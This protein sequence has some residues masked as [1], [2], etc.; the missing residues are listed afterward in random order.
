MALLYLA[1]K[2]M[3]GGFFIYKAVRHFMNP[4]TITDAEGIHGVSFPAIRWGMTGL[5]FLLCGL[6]FLFGYHPFYGLVWCGSALSQGNPAEEKSLNA[7]LTPALDEG[8]PSHGMQ[9]TS[10]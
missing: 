4:W 8:S 9:G 3:F 6:C 10:R 5:T 7:I 1:A 2:I